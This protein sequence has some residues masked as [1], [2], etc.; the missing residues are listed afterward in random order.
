[1]LVLNKCYAQ[2]TF[3]HSAR[4]GKHDRHFERSRE[5]NECGTTDN[6]LN[7]DWH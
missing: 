1:M 6:L 4:I 5:K 2:P 7:L 3:L